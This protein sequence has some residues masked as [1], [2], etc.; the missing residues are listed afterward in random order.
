MKTYDVEELFNY[1]TECAKNCAEDNESFDCCLPCVISSIEDGK[2]HDLDYQKHGDYFFHFSHYACAK[3]LYTDVCI[4][5]IQKNE[6]SILTADEID[7]MRRMMFLNNPEWILCKK[8][9][10]LLE[11][12]YTCHNLRLTDNI[13]TTIDWFDI[14]AFADSFDDEEIQ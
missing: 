12:S 10:V 5:S 7:E 8:S 11:I 14:N 13:L 6:S 3:G 1:C 4:K 9:F 2:L